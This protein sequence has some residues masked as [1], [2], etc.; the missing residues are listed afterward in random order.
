MDANLNYIDVE[1]NE[2][3][4]KL[5]SIVAHD[6]GGAELLSSYV[7][8]HKDL[9]FIYALSGPALNI[10]ERK[11]GEISNYSILDAISKSDIIFCGTGWGSRFELKGIMIA[12]S[13]KKKSIAFLDHWVSYRERFLLN[14][15]VI[16]PDEIWVGDKYAHSYA[17]EIFP[18]T[19]IRLIQNYF[20]KDLKKEYKKFIINNKDHPKEISVLFISDNIDAVIANDSQKKKY[21]N[22][23]DNEI[24][25]YLIKNLDAL[26]S[27]VKQISIRPHPSELNAAEK[28]KLAISDCK[29]PCFIGGKVNLLEEIANNDIV[30]GGDSMALVVSMLCG[31]KTFT[32]IPP[33]GT[34]TLPFDEIKRIQND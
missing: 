1:N 29:I 21:L 15:K 27:K 19:Q 23:S 17:S 24:F 8:H 31:K 18:N 5:I 13:M 6:A 14:G 3:K 26:N 4:K 2:L 7:I 28:Y 16:L 30:V 22:F 9:K 12:Q 33:G 11:F 20:F 25:S 34:Y 10:F 32:C